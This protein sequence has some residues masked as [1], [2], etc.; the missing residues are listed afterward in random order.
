[1]T[2]TVLHIVGHVGTD[3]DHR[4]VGNGSHLSQ[5]RLATTPRYFDRT[6]RAYVN[7]V[8]NWLSVQCWRNLAMHVR[9]SLKRGDPVVVVGKLKTQEWVTPDGARHSRFILEA[10][11]VG[12]DLSRGVSS[13]TKMARVAES[14]PDHTQAAVQAAQELEE[15]TVDLSPEP[16]PFADEPLANA[17]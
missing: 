5:F 1:M 12:H 8:T 15:S 7:G 3:V 13:F 9:D 16:D 2:D 6:Q 4:E 11:A 10:I 17:S 14:F